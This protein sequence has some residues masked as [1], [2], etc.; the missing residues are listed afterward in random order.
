[1]SHAEAMKLIKSGR[2]LV[3]FDDLVLDVS[4]YRF[5][6]PGGAVMFNKS[7]G[8]D[9]GKYL[10]GC[11]S[12]GGKFNPWNHSPQAF[13]IA[14][15]LAIAKL[16]SKYYIGPISDGKIG[17]SD[18]SNTFGDMSGRIETE[19]AASPSGVPNETFMLSEGYW[20]F[21]DKKLVA[22]NTYDFTLKSDDV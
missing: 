19:E 11:S 22:Q 18:N 6:H 5:S 20:E 21:V 14:R 2:K 8:Q 1:M 17:P 9:V 16:P 12:I 7:I 4:T 3:F 13:R 10:N 15:Q